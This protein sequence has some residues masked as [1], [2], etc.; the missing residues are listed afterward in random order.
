MVTHDSQRFPPVQ[1]VHL[2][3]DMGWLGARGTMFLFLAQIG[4]IL[5]LMGK[6]SVYFSDGW[7]E[8]RPFGAHSI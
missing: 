2:P 8:A 3:Q 1:G 6:S 4:A 7:P 5:G